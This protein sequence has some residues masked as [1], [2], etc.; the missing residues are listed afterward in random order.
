MVS[1][2]TFGVAQRVDLGMEA[3]GQ[4]GVEPRAVTDGRWASG[5]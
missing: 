4:D 3:L 5:Y 2:V 1:P